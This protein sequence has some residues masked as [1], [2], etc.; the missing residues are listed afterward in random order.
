MNECKT[1][2]AK[3]QR[4]ATGAGAVLLTASGIAT[5]FA[6]ASCCALPILLGGLGISTAWLFGIAVLAAP[7][8]ALLLG[9]SAFALGA[10]AA[11]L[12]RQRAVACAPGAWCARPG[13]RLMTSVGLILGMVLLAVGY[14]YA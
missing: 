3:P 14:A 6:V 9:V 13:V 5:A 11:A 7:H 8:R 12:W 10:G 2:P 4:P 1:L